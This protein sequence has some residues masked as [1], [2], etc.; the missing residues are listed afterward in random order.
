MNEPPSSS[1]DPSSPPALFRHPLSSPTTRPPADDLANSW[2]LEF[3][4]RQP[5]PERLAH[6]IFL[7][8]PFSSFHP[9]L[10]KTLLLRRLSSE[11]DRQRLSESTLHSLELIEE[12]D[13]LN[14]CPPSDRLKAAYCAAAVECA[15]A[16]SRRGA[17]D[18][19]EVVGRIWV[20]RVVDL[21]RSEAAAGLLSKPLVEW[22]NRMEQWLT[23]AE[24]IED[25]MNRDVAAAMRPLSD[26]L[27]DA[28][29]GMGPPFLEIAAAEV[30]DNGLYWRG[31]AC[32]E[33]KEEGDDD[34]GLT[35]LNRHLGNSQEQGKAL[36]NNGNVE[37]CVRFVDVPMRTLDDNQVN[38]S[39]TNLEDGAVTEVSPARDGDS[40]NGNDSR[41]D[42][43]EEEGLKAGGHKTYKQGIRLNHNVDS[44][45]V[46]KVKEALIKSYLELQMAVEDPLP[47]AQA[48]AAAVLASFSR[49]STIHSGPVKNKE[50]T[51]VQIPHVQTVAGGTSNVGTSSGALEKKKCDLMAFADLVDTQPLHNKDLEGRRNVKEFNKFAESSKGTDNVARL[52]LKECDTTAQTSEVISSWSDDSFKSGSEKSHNPIKGKPSLSRLDKGQL[53]KRRTVKRWSS[54]E[55]STLRQAVAKYGK[56]NWKVILKSYAEIFEDRTEVDLKD[57]WRNMSRHFL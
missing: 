52:N 8:L 23:D 16:A 48:T 5:I 20:G 49:F 44:G 9:H 26:Y 57:K 25:L 29:E 31:V 10:R 3:I 21:A 50:S 42:E 35:K 38:A 45:E 30:L 46:R 56:G 18:F 37:K 1:S 24:G 15:V 41:A 43:V 6:D 13:R 27:K 11:L 14:G 17:G 19:A 33:G 4:L 47:E 12:L 7:S 53:M 34:R 32:K 36:V 39:R 51:T 55:E 54:L 40:M 2:I 22:A 28:M